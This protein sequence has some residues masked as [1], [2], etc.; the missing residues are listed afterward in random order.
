MDPNAAL[1]RLR[2]AM[3]DLSGRVHPS[4]IDPFGSL[5][6]IRDALEAFEALDEWLTNGGFLPAAWS[7][8]R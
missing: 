1:A 5:D 4:I 2:D 8:G 6:D 3:N 7:K